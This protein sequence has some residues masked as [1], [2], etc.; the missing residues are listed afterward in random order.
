MMAKHVPPENKRFDDIIELEEAIDDMITLVDTVR[1]ASPAA[2]RHDDPAIAAAEDD[3]ERIIGRVFGTNSVEFGQFGYMKL[4]H[5]G[6]YANW[7]D[8]DWQDSFRKAHPVA[9][10]RLEG[11]LADLRRRRQRLPMYAGARAFAAA[12]AAPA[13][14]PTGVRSGAPHATHITQNNY[15]PIYGQAV[16][17]NANDVS[18]RQDASAAQVVTALDGLRTQL[19][20]SPTLSEAQKSD[21]AALV[22]VLRENA[23]APAEA[24]AKS[25]AVIRTALFG[26][27]AMTEFLANAGPAVGALVDTLRHWFHM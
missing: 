21:A 7:S 15:G 23:L 12:T 11:L 17:G 9:L 16:A 8:K 6:S 14:G 26:I 18:L 19:L 22:A 4:T 24:R 3:I 2:R 25:A 27:A 1:A 20:A 5:T 10:A 13:P